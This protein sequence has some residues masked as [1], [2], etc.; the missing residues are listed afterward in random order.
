MNTPISILIPTYNYLVYPLVKEL[1]SQA[2]LLNTPFEIIVVNDASKLYNE[3]NLALS[4]LENVH[5]I[6][7]ENNLGRTKVRQL[8]AQK[9]NFDWLLFMDA[10][11]IPK[12]SSFLDIFLQTL[13]T[14]KMQCVFGGISYQEELPHKNYALRW[15]YGRKREHLSLSI[16][17]KNPYV[18][19][20]SGC[21]LIQK[22]IFNSINEK[23]S[24]IDRYGLDLYF[25]ELLKQE[26][27]SV[28]HIDNEVIHL[29]L[30]SSEHYIKKSLEAVETLYFLEKNKYIKENEYP[31][32][33]TFISLKKYHLIKIT[34]GVYA[35]SKK[36]MEKNLKSTMPNLRVFDF[37]RLGFYI[38]L[39]NE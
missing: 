39:K 34:H 31:L 21:F 1:Q 23:L 22:S 11:V 27:V 26:S 25:K 8:L 4:K 18:T 14:N 3:Q 13:D 29:G 10:D 12:K 36:W 37:Y 15:Y 17:N 32:Q 38:Q 7:L 16:R 35:L 2:L 19:I 5:Y 33:K 28:K 24:Q 6:Q 9:A 20:N 30:E